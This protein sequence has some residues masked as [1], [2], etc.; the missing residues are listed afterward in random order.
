MTAVGERL[1]LGG[2]GGGL[3]QEGVELLLQEHAV[4]HLLVCGIRGADPHVP[5]AEAA[6]A[7][8]GAELHV[9]PLVPRDPSELPRLLL[10][11]RAFV[12]S[13]LDDDFSAVLVA[14]SKGASRSVAVVLAHL[15]GEL[16]LAEAFERVAAA[17]WRVW[18][19][20]LLVEAL[21]GLEEWE[22]RAAGRAPPGAA[23]RRAVCR[24]V[25]SHA[26]LATAWHNGAEA[27]PGGAEAAWD[28]GEEGMPLEGA[29]AA[30]KQRLLGLRGQDLAAYRGGGRPPHAEVSD[31]GGG[32]L[33]CGLG[34][35]APEAVAA[36]L[37]EHGVARVVV[38]GRPRRD[39]HVDAL[40]AALR[41]G[42]RDPAEAHVVPV[43][44]SAAEDLLAH[45]EAA[46]RFLDEAL[47]APAARVLVC[48]RQ[49]ASRSASVAAARL[50]A[51]EALISYDTI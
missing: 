17:R 12:D 26:A 13:A 42:G 1:L 46:T 28:A 32:V 45:L 16:R 4:T 48:C 2:L 15:M 27:D 39:A 18:P 5:V 19:S 33:L 7:A 50:M 34:G 37:R 24:R 10:E 30:C 36:L 8:C 21:L 35:M 20:A 25:G 11:A 44:D 38:C 29:F 51:A 23:E 14:C 41:V 31:L 6:A 49:G 3:S 22:L 47:A 43:G 40:L 9:A